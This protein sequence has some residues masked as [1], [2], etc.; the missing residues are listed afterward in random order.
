MVSFK[1]DV[2]LSL[3]RYILIKAISEL[4][5]LKDN[6]N[7]VDAYQRV[8]F[9]ILEQKFLELLDDG[10]FSR[11]LFCLRNELSCTKCDA[12]RLQQLSM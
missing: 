10:K 11:A 12:Q 8:K 9:A 1:D 5:K 7:D 4:K 6:L 2:E 3:Y